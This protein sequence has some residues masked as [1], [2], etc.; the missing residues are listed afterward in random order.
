MYWKL[1]V[2]ERDPETADYRLPEGDLVSTHR[3]LSSQMIN[4]GPNRLNFLGAQ[5]CIGYTGAECIIYADQSQT[6]QEVPVLIVDRIGRDYFTT[7]GD[8]QRQQIDSFM[9][10]AY[11]S[12]DNSPGVAIQIGDRTSRYFTL[13]WWNTQRGDFPANLPPI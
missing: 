12:S 8:F 1:Y 11:H 10:R 3:Y 2:C 9:C 13:E 6:P 5:L 4:L 7:L